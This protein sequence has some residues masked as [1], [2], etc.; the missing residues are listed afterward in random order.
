MLNSDYKE[1]L[2][3]GKLLL[4]LR[5][6]I[7][8]VRVYIGDRKY[9]YQSLKT[10]KIELA[11][12][13]AIKCYYEIGVRLEENLPIFQKSLNDVIDEYIKFRERDYERTKDLVINS[14]RQQ[15]T[16]YHNLRQ[17]KRAAKFWREYC[18]KLAVVRIDNTVLKDFIPWRRDYYPNKPKELWPKNARPNPKDKTLQGESVFGLTLLKYAHERGY[19]G[20]TQMPTYWYS[21]ETYIVRPA[22]SASEYATVFKHLLRYGQLINKG[23][24]ENKTLAERLQDKNAS[25]DLLRKNY[26]MELLCD[27]MH[28][29][30][31]SGLRVGEANNL[32]VSDI[33]QITDGKGRTNYVLYVKGKT[34]KRSVVPQVAAVRHIQ[35]RLHVHQDQSRFGYLKGKGR[36]NKENKGDWLFRMPDGNK[37][38][39]LIDQFQAVLK[40]IG[41]DFNRYKER[42]T[43][44]SL[45]HFYASRAIQRDKEIF[46]IA[47][48]MGTSVQVIQRYYGR[49]ATPLTYATSLGD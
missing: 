4:Y 6:G 29:L 2:E 33:E 26:M 34:G 44:Y 28:V 32:L 18:G 24:S 46:Q 47:R 38:T 35:R 27:Y 11:R 39:T 42:Y 30:A 20:K 21:A 41:I 1:E 3:D 31:S 16:T 13:L 5:N 15:H 49:S 8:Y 25:P 7:F 14:A 17:I 36:R 23:N 10:S 19:R 45:R 12:K 9:K 48:N 22:F 43:L 40:E 37:I